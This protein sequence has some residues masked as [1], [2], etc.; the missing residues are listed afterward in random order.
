M[1]WG[2]LA[3]TVHAQCPDF[4]DLTSSSVTGY[5]GLC[6]YID[7]NY[8]D[9]TLFV[10]IIP[11][12]HTLI[13]QQGT[14]P[15]TGGQLPLLPSGENMVVKLGNEQIGAQWE[16]LVYTF[17]VD[18]DYPVLLLKYAIVLEDPHHIEVDQPRF[19]IQMLDA[20]D[21]LLSGCMEYNVVSSPLI[22]GFQEYNHV[23]WRPWTTNGFDLSAYAGQTVK[24]KITTY[25]CRAGGHYGYAYF[26]ASC[27][28]N[29]ITFSGCNG[30]QVTL[31]APVGFESYSWNNG[32]HTPTT[33]YTIQPNT[34][35]T[36]DIVTVTGCQITHS[37][38]FTQDTILQD[39][40]YYDTICEGMGYADH[41]FNLPVY[42]S[43]G[44]YIA[45]N[46]YYDA[47]DCVEEATNTLYLHV[48]PR[49]HHLYDVACE[50]DNYNAHGFHL[51][52]LTQGEMT[53]TTYVPLPYGCDSTTILHLT[54]NHTFS[55][56]ETING[57]NVVC[58]GTS[59]IYTLV[60]APSQTLYHWTAPDGVLIYGGQGT[61][62]AQL[63]FM[64]NSPSSVLVTLT[65]DNGCGSATIPVNI[66]VGASHSNMFS[67]TICTG[68]TYMQHG[69][70]LGTQDTAGYYVHILNGTTQQG[71]DSVSV[72]EL[73]V[74]ET[75]SVEAMADPAEL[76][77]GE[78]TELHALGSQASVT[79]TSQLPKVWV[80]DILC[81]DSTTVH[82]E[83]WPCG[84]VA[85][86]IV[87]YVDNTG[88]HGW[89]VALQD[90][91][92]PNT[93]M[94]GLSIQNDILT[95]INFSNGSY[96]LNDVDGYQNTLIIRQNGQNNEYE[97]AYAVDFLHGWY[98]PA[99]GQIYKLYAE[100][101]RMNSSLQLVG[102]SI[103]DLDA[104]WTYWTSTEVSDS[105]AWVL[106]KQNGFSTSE[107][108][109]PHNVRGVRTF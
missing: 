68:N 6:G 84:K 17:T 90:V 66:T 24:F 11:E 39:H 31:S 95:L 91:N 35:A 53:D 5:A 109:Y 14:D 75:P 99:A 33:T 76:C 4:T 8:V 42:S 2:L 62:S 105:R 81:T 86:G 52:Q 74:A 47:S 13:T 7:G 23:M 79:L 108:N 102:G 101:I 16:S 78:E 100:M 104:P 77:V 97:A 106:D 59:E 1:L 15:N 27:I 43:P 65:A 64:P 82:P 30:N 45:S 54:V 48:H 28:S 20:N 22:P 38:T 25:D 41:G 83:D 37:V 93:Y 19:L 21:Q 32:S 56:S 61:P 18:S 92:A 26:T 73:F 49:Y 58:S 12:R 103:F 70:Q 44:E 71:C 36:C 85:M 96:A 80:G 40:V 98:L 67:D 51:T 50:G 107:K 9:T 57:P 55:M 88:E 60:N 10:G 72:L 94:W 46:T 89:A 3:L 29:Q 69:Y 87:F 63:Y 34:V